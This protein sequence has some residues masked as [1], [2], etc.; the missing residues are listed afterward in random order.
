M[1]N[2]VCPLYKEAVDAQPWRSGN[3][4]NAGLLFDKFANAWAPSEK[5]WE[6]DKNHGAES[7]LEKFSG[8]KPGNSDALAESRRR[9]QDLV[10][11]LGGAIL[12]LTN[13]SRFVTGMGRQHPLEN[14][15]AWHHTL[16]APYLPGSSLKGV[17]RAWMREEEGRWDPNT[18]RWTETA[19]TQ[20]WFGV[21]DAAGRFIVLD[22][23][24]TN[25]PTLAV[26]VMTPHYSRYYQKGECPG[27]W[28][29]PVPIQFLAV[30]EGNQW[31][32][33]LLPAPGQRPLT[34]DEL[35]TLKQHLTDALEWLGAGAKTAGGYGCFQRD[36]EAEESLQQEAEQRRREHAQQRAREQ[37]L[38]K[39]A[40]ELAELYRRAEAEEW[41][42]DNSRF[43]T[44]VEK[45]LEDTPT[46]IPDC[47]A[48]LREQMEQRWPGIWEDPD[49]TKGKK[50]K[51]AYKETQRRIVHRLKNMLE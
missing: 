26:E 23:L 25:V 38:R 10:T 39:M 15:F 34:Q 48:W 11:F 3:A 30:D 41:N 22:M 13:A 35:A 49:K 1:P 7:W 21:Q 36:A 50:Q 33:G 17:L 32:T 8:L 40:P 5:T 42:R 31:Q 24:P 29:S 6:F 19:I 45:Y 16:G 14:G 20:D 37:E 51:P 18:G 43:L 12:C 27:D 46:P 28:H 47:I 44:G 9:Q 4:A 2:T